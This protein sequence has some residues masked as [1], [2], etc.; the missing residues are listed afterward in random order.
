MITQKNTQYIT[1]R[2]MCSR[3][4]NWNRIIFD[5]NIQIMMQ[6]VIS[7][8]E[9]QDIMVLPIHTIYFLHII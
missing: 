8:R 6:S 4:K 3:L 7:H 1:K 9:K 2:R 5:K